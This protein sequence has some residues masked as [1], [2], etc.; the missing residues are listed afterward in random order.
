MRMDDLCSVDVKKV[1][2]KKDCC[3][4]CHGSRKIIFCDTTFCLNKLTTYEPP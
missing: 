1:S 2:D 4:V 3:V